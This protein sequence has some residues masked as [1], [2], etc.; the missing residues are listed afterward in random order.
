MGQNTSIS[1]RYIYIT[2]IEH[3]MF[4]NIW[5]SVWLSH[6]LIISGIILGIGTANKRKHYYVI[7]SLIGR[8]HIQ[9]DPWMNSFIM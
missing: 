9:N 5:F 4:I 6:I 7:P 3:L 2:L 1:V 8:T